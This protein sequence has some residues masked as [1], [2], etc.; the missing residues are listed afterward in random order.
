MHRY[1][2]DRRLCSRAARKLCSL[3]FQTSCALQ[4]CNHW[5]G[6]L[7]SWVRK[8]R[9][10]MEPT[11]HYPYGNQGSRAAGRAFLDNSP[12][13]AGNSEPVSKQSFGGSRHIQL[14]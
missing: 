1:I 2:R 11:G 3:Y 14:W 6:S 8:P 4:A 12:I 9:S 13:C 10:D 7:H 5:R